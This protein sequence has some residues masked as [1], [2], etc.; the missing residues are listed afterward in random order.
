MTEVNLR[1]SQK[2]HGCS[3]TID[4]GLREEAQQPMGISNQDGSYGV[5][6]SSSHGFD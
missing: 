4:L 6:T 5:P 1:N 2:Y 3:V